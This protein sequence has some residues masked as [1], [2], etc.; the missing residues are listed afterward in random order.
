MKSDKTLLKVLNADAI[1]II[2]VIVTM[3]ASL[4]YIGTSYYGASTATDKV[5]SEYRYKVKSAEVTAYTNDN[6]V[7]NSCVKTQ[8]GKVCGSFV[9]LDNPDF[10]GK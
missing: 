4:F 5:K 1:I 3:T 8:S 2:A 9:I 6:S 10:E 7:H